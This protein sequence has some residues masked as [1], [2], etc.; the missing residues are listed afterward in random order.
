MRVCSTTNL[1]ASES[2]PVQA[3]KQH[4]RSSTSSSGERPSKS[5]TSP[6]LTSLP[7]APGRRDFPPFA[8]FAFALWLGWRHRAPD[9]WHGVT[10]A[11]SKQEFLRLANLLGGYNVDRVMRP[12]MTPFPDELA[13]WSPSDPELVALNRRR[14]IIFG[15]KH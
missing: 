10:L 13:V 6:G 4:P 14:P 12:T 15:M 1:S 8:S 11:I 3:R 9:L 2:K 7:P 5:S